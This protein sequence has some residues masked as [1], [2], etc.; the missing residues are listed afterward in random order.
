[1]IY[2]PSEFPLDPEFC[3]LNH[4]AISPWPRRTAERVAAMAQRIM[5]CGGADYPAWLGT[6]QQLRERIAALL[7]APDADDI[8]LL[9]NT[10]DGLSMISQGLD[11]QDGD[12]VVGVAG[13]FCSNEMVWQALGD[14]GVEYTGVDTGKVQDQE[15]VL[16]D[17]LAPNT[18]LL[19]VSTV[20]F[21]TGYRYDI[22][23]LGE[24]CRERGVL[25]SVD[26]IQSLG[27][28]RFDLAET[29]ADF[30][31][32]GGHKW[33]LSPEGIGFLYCRA[34][35]RER[36][37]LH[38]YGWAMRDTPYDFEPE[39]PWRPASSAR[40]FE[41]GTPNML[42]IHAMEASL[43]LFA[44]LGMPFV[45]QRLADNVTYLY[46]ALSAID[47]IEMVTTADPAKRAGIVTFRHRDIDGQQLHRALTERQLICSPRGGGVRLAPHFYTSQ[48]VL[49]RSI[50]IIQQSIQHMK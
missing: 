46:D 22:A 9:K 43:S 19:A 4:A 29:P 30:V 34:E 45:E 32:C 37:A 36:I 48:A 16:I 5:T 20:H 33:L 1:M 12:G 3:Y 40:R 13:D 24:A 17:A 41:A 27:A 26:G 21:A 18:R 50:S 8:A 28:L 6:E 25:L 23:R 38:Q 49:E 39:G 10:S 35:L 2:L 42:G 31:T 15:A 44:E 47:G 14:R 7:N 11:W